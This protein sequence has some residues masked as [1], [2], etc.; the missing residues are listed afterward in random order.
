MTPATKDDHPE[1]THFRAISNPAE[2]LLT[3][4]CQQPVL[5]SARMT[6]P[7][8]LPEDTV[9]QLVAALNAGDLALAETLYAPDACFV[10]EPGQCVRG[11]TEIRAALAGLISLQPRLETHTFKVIRNDDLALYHSRWSLRGVTPDGDAV[12][13]NGCSADVLRRCPDGR[14]LIEIDN[15]Y[16]PEP[17]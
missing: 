8:L 3:D 4:G 15:P 14:W 9:R 12:Q 11:R 10:P 17:L 16:G 6:Q 2:R 13:Q 1:S 7:S 5:L